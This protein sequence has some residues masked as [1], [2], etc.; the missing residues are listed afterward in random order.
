MLRFLR[1]VIYVIIFNFTKI[2]LRKE[3][4]GKIATVQVK[5]IEYPDL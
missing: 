5:N 4:A 3:A 1:N 2:S